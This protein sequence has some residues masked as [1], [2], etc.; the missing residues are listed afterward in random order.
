[1]MENSGLIDL[2]QQR[3]KCGECWFTNDVIDISE[4]IGV[5]GWN[6]ML[7]DGFVCS[8]AAVSN[9]IQTFLCLGSLGNNNRQMDIIIISLVG[10]RDS[11]PDD[12][13]LLC[14]LLFYI[15]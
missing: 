12:V 2:Y 15:Y 10:L 11:R 3:L 1:M 7:E 8:L 4:D 5:M 6:K 14:S 9:V 13:S